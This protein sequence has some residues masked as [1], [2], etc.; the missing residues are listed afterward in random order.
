MSIFYKLK[1]IFI[2]F[3]F[4]INSFAQESLWDKTKSAVSNTANKVADT[5]TDV[6]S[7][8]PSPEQAR[9]KINRNAGKAL[10]RL[11]NESKDAKNIYD[12]SYGYAV[13]D[14]REFAFMIK[15][16]FGSGVAIRKADKSRTYMK[17]A[18]GGVNIGGG[19]KYI[20]IIFLFP[21][22]KTLSN[23]INNGWNADGDASAVGGK[24]SAKIGITLSD[25]TKIYELTDTGLMLKMSLSGTKY[26]KDSDLN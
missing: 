26:W 23:F 25:G 5:A 19:I 11:F 10:S 2:L 8:K 9:N 24:D 16:G 12:K 21:T 6:V 7:D 15:T 18:S 14:S 13:F 20:Q 3:I 1:V 4:S 22:D 17:M